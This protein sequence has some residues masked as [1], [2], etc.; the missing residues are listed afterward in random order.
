MLAV[1]DKSIV[2]CRHGRFANYFG[3]FL[4]LLEDAFAEAMEAGEPVDWGDEL[5][6]EMWS[7]S[8]DDCDND[9]DGIAINGFLAMRLLVSLLQESDGVEYSGNTYD[10]GGPGLSSALSVFY[11]ED[12]E[13]VCN[14]VMAALADRLHIEH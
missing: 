13:A 4:T 11:A 6:R 2:E 14:Q 1:V 3:K 10:G 8:V 9:P 7:D 12:P 5:I